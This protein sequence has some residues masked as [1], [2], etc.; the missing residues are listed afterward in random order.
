MAWVR[1]QSALRDCLKP[2]LGTDSRQTLKDRQPGAG[3]H[4]EDDQICAESLRP[5]PL[6]ASLLSIPRLEGYI[7]GFSAW[8]W[9]LT[10][11]DVITRD[12]AGV[13]FK[14]PGLQRQRRSEPPCCT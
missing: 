5:G 1:R 12:F 11:C 13:F 14:G 10:N 4:G 8:E 3:D 2:F 6:S 9:P 7:R